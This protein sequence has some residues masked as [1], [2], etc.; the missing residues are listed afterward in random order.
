MTTID[1]KEVIENLGIKQALA[2]TFAKQGGK[3]EEE[4]LK[5]FDVIMENKL[6]TIGK[7]LSQGKVD[8]T[9]FSRLRGLSLQDFMKENDKII[10]DK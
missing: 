9:Q 1:L 6:E 4:Y 5:M 7:E 3:T 2:K 8:E 10:K